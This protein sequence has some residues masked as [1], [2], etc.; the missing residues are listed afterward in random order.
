M[1]AP[2]TTADW[3]DIRLVVFDVDG[4]LYRQSTLRR[5]ML[6]ELLLHTV[7]KRDLDALRVLG[8]YRRIREKLADDE[9]VDFDRHLL[10]ETSSATSRSADQVLATVSEWISD[11][12]LPYLRGCVYAGVAQLF[13]G[14]KREGKSIGIL[15]DYPAAT[16]LA[17]MGLAA[18]YIV[19]ASD[20]GLLKPHPKGLQT[21]MEIA[22]VT[23]R[24]TILIGDRAE[25]D[26]RA[27]KRAGVATLIRSS[28][29]VEGVQTFASF[30]DPLF[31][32]FQR[33]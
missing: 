19:A 7:I 33:A 18:D 31:A 4:T 2:F 11:R 24:E 6:R 16:K 10:A 28:K 3:A 23:A 30:E 27:G 9:V 25:R 8:T 22:G 29:P 5:K 20:V 12:P 1:M 13:A 14:L 26:G 21:L 32:P 17:A 15:S